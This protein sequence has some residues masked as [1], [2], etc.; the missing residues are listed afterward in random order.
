MDHFVTEVVTWAKRGTSAKISMRPTLDQHETTMPMMTAGFRTSGHAT[1][2]CKRKKKP[3]LYFLVRQPSNTGQLSALFEIL[4]LL[5]AHLRRLSSCLT[6]L[7]HIAFVLRRSRVAPISVTWWLFAHFLKTITMC[8]S[9]MQASLFCVE[10]QHGDSLRLQGFCGGR[11][12]HFWRFLKYEGKGM[13]HS[14][15]I[16]FKFV[17][18]FVYP[19]ALSLP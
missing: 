15:W 17:A 13:Q 16:L 18:I 3:C 9:F 4:Y 5:S 1:K 7:R 11:E 14:Q 2:T 19:L 8:L 10:L 6:C 12:E